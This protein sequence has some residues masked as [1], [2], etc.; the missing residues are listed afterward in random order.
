[1]VWPRFRRHHAFPFRSDCQSDCRPDCRSGRKEDQLAR[2]ERN[3]GRCSTLLRA[4]RPQARHALP[5]CRLQEPLEGPPIPLRVR[6]AHEAVQASADRRAGYLAKWRER[7]D[8][9]R[10]DSAATSQAKCCG[11]T[12][13]RAG[14][15][16]PRQ[17]FP[18]QE[19]IGSHQSLPLHGNR[20]SF[21]EAY[22]SCRSRNVASVTRMRS[23]SPCDSIRL[24]VF[25]ASPQRSKTNFPSRS[26]RPRQG[27]CARRCG[28]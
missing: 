13:N 11:L 17:S 26:R 18:A 15:P 21:G 1:M 14:G 19:K 9:R 2:P 27:R 20:P 12:A 7:Q 10:F 3:A 6:G 5:L 24:A 4:E 8:A 22:L 28:C 25:T 16:S 23:R